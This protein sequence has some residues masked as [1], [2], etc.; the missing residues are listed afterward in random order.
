MGTL[1][2]EELNNFIIIMRRKLITSNRK[3][4]ITIIW[5]T[6]SFQ[7]KVYSHQDEHS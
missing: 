5:A 6:L 4:L 3:A 7:K 1:V 2:K